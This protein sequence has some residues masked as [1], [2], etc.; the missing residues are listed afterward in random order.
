MRFTAVDV[1]RAAGGRLVG[2]DVPLSGASFDSRTV[3]PGQLFVPVVADRDGHEFVADALSR[4]A[5]AY[6]SS[7][8]VTD[9][10]TVIVVDDTVRAL[11]AVA[12]WARGRLNDQLAGRSVG[13]TGSVGKTTT[14]DL[15]A[16]ALA[17]SL[18]VAAS[19]RSF[20][21]D[22]G[23]P[24]TILNAPDDV[25][26]LVL[27][28]G[29]R[30]LGEIDRLCQVARPT[31]GVVTA[32][33]EAHTERVGGI[34]GVARAK[35]E[36]VAALPADGVAVLN[37]DDARV[38]AMRAVA[39]CAVMTYGTSEGSDVRMSARVLDDAGRATIEVDTPWGAT[40]VR[41]GLPG[42]HMAHN[43]LAAVAVAGVLGVSIEHAVEAIA[44]VESPPMRMQVRHT[45]TG[46]MVI[47]DCYNANPASMQAALETLA[48]LDARRRV[49]VAG[50]LA[51]L[52][53]PEI[54][55]RAVAVLID[56]LGIELV[57]VGTDLYGPS[58][59]SVEHAIDVLASLTAGDAALVK[60]SRVARLERV[61]E[62]ATRV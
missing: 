5:G 27:E 18:R 20:N 34:E 62:G 40:C 15:V 36:L 57:P 33:A 12:A 49:V 46:A 8:G 37:A 50:E 23:L 44:L 22:Q 1:A 61:V 29:M 45:P 48:S 17:T 42:V 59:V 39:P 30:G 31:V 56:R 38:V 60:G 53:H 24:V 54:A 19:P 32:V 11:G 6:L 35:A 26:A 16:A 55:H 41:M 2:P 9:G 10:D 4:G 25:E 28:M 13:I 14:K 43:A 47:D 21:N 7:Q 3:E 51:E 52:E 58:A